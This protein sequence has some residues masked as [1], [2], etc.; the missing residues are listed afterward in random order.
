MKEG[1]AP[2]FFAAPGRRVGAQET[3][4]L[5]AGRKIPFHGEKQLL[6]SEKAEKADL[7]WKEGKIKFHIQEKGSTFTVR[8]RR[9]VPFVM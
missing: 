8:K 4:D 6:R 1:A 5:G 2:L 9:D 7:L 3:P